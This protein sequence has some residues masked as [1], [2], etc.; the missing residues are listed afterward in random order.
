MKN[1]FIMPKTA[2]LSLMEEAA[3][4]VL[5]RQAKDKD[6]LIHICRETMA[7]RLSIKD[8]DTISKYTNKL[9]KEKYIWKV[10]GFDGKGHNLVKY[11]IKNCEKYRILGND[12]YNVDP[13]LAAF[14]SR[15]SDHR[16]NN[17]NNIYLNNRELAAKMNM[18]ERTFYKYIAQAIKAGIVTKTGEGYI[19]AS[20]YFPIKGMVLNNEENSIFQTLMKSGTAKQAKQIIWYNNN[21]IYE[22]DS[23]RRIFN[24]IV[25]NT[26][27]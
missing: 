5:C 1:Y 27:K 8:V 18:K 26:L 7:E 3:L 6:D 10:D 19:L 9:V 14:S 22:V 24:Q 2:N 4:I 12:L 11:G 15:L 20:K 23:D 16:L 13:K 17:T 25:S 21:K